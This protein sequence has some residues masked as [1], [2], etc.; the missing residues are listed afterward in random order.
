MSS[1]QIES[2]KLAL[3]KYPE[4]EPY[5]IQLRA[6]CFPDVAGLDV[7][8][9]FEEVTHQTGVPWTF[10]LTFQL[11]GIIPDKLTF[12]IPLF[13]IEVQKLMNREADYTQAFKDDHDV[14]FLEKQIGEYSKNYHFVVRN[15]ALTV[16]INDY[17]DHLYIY[18]EGFHDDLELGNTNSWPDEKDKRCTA[19]YNAWNSVTTGGGHWSG[20]SA[21]KTICRGNIQ[22]DLDKTKAIITAVKPYV[23][24]DISL[25]KKA[26]HIAKNNLMP[27]LA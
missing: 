8:E 15:K 24:S 22:K 1:K 18:I 2:M 16:C 13:I 21:S 14:L 5:Y 19:T 4:L 27:E 20:N 11:K 23:S 10:Q 25:R 26:Y 6:L 12:Q 3:E 9:D 17:G 7:K